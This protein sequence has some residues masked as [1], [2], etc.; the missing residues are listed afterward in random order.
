[1]VDSTATRDVDPESFVADPDPTSHLL[2]FL[3][4]QKAS[5]N[6]SFNTPGEN[7]FVSLTN[8]AWQSASAMEKPS[9][10]GLQ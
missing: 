8:I 3:I 7:C 10:F 4:L 6:K 2:T 9:S 5:N 1:M